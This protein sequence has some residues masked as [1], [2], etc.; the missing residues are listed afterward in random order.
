MQIQDSLK[1]P[2]Y[3]QRQEF[4]TDQV[5]LGSLEAAQ[6][7]CGLHKIYD[8]QKVKLCRLLP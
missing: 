6:I 8:G 3:A 1:K 7:A 4:W 2:D 5:H